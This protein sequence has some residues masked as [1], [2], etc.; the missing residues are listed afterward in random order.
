MRTATTRPGGRGVTTTTCPRASIA[1]RNE[2]LPGRRDYVYNQQTVGN[3]GEIP[4]AQSGG[5]SFT[6]TD[7]V[8]DGAN[9]TVLVPTSGS[10]GSSWTLEGFD[11]S[12][13][14]SGTTGVGFDNGTGYQGLF[15]HRHGRAH[16][17]QPVLL[18]PRALHGG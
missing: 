12:S 8:A 14:I 16:D 10:L 11:D 2:Y 17:E 9:A 1:Y 4:D 13:W 5:V 6:Y 18:H 15:K 7:V 3:G